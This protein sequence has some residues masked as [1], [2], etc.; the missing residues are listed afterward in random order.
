MSRFAKLVMSLEPTT[1]SPISAGQSV[2]GRFGTEVKWAFSPP[3]NWLGGVGA[4]LLLSLLWLLWTPLTGRSHGSWIVLVGTYFAVFIL[5]DVTTTNV[6]GADAE[7]VRLSLIRDV[8]VTRLLITKNLVLVA[9]VG[10]PTLLLTAVLTLASTSS[11]RLVMTLPGVALPVLAWL[12]VGNLISVLLPVPVK[13]S[14][15]RWRERHDKRATFRWLAHLALPYL[16]LY[17]VNKASAIP[18]GVMRALPPHFHTPELMGILFSGAGLLLWSAGTLAAK[19]V[20]HQRGFALPA[21]NGRPAM[22]VRR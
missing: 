14:P 16:L 11:Y 8:P 19:W 17:E 18:R 7:R 6:L 1:E 20:I 5:A 22:T 21:S 13:S 3:W 12:G 10:L 4:N 15:Q 9:V 2:F